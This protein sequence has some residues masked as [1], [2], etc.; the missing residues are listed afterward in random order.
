MLKARLS[1]WKCHNESRAPWT[2]VLRAVAFSPRASQTGPSLISGCGAPTGL[3]ILSYHPSCPPETLCSL[4]PQRAS[5][6]TGSLGRKGAGREGPAGA[7]GLK[8]NEESACTPSAVRNWAFGCWVP[9]TA[10]D[11]WP[12]WCVSLQLPKQT[13][14]GPG[15]SRYPSPGLRVCEPV[16]SRCPCPARWP[17][18]EARPAQAS[19]RRGGETVGPRQKLSPPVSGQPPLA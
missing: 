5:D 3:L 16:R 12:Q 17:C 14:G 4:L 2:S 19:V 8:R 1:A 15:R 6:F 11:H 18:R 13:S 10:G 7:P 9:G